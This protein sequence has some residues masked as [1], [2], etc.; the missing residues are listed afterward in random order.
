VRRAALVVLI[1]AGLVG[2]QGVAAQTCAELNAE[3]ARLQQTVA[4][5]QAGLANCRNR[6]GICTPGQEQSFQQAIDIANSEI[7]AD[8]NKLRTACAPPPPPDFD[9]VSLQGIEV[10]QAIQDMSNSVTLVSGKP[11]WVRVYFDKITGT[12]PLTANLV[13]ARGAT[14][15]TIAPA[16]A[17][18]VDPTENL[19]TRRTTWTKSLNFQVPAAMEAVG[20]T[21]FT[22]SGVKD[23]SPQ[24]KTIK[25]AN[26]D[27]PTTVQFLNSP[28]LVV[29]AVG[30]TYTFRS[31]PPPTPLQTGTPRAVDFTLLQSWLGRAYPVSTVTFSQTSAASTNTW[32]FTCTQANAQL[33]ALR[34]TEIAGGRDSHTHY[35]GLVSNAGGFMRGCSSGVPATAD[36]TTT[37]AG[38][39][40]PTSGANTPVNVTGDNDGSF[41][42]WYGGHELA[43]TFGRA[44]PGFCNGNS[45]SDAL[46]PNPNGQLSDGTANAGVGLDVGD[47]ASA[48]ALTVMWGGTNYDVMTYCNQPQWFS[49]YAYEGVRQ[50]LLDENPGFVV[51]ALQKQPATGKTVGQFVHV[52]GSLNLTK[53]TGRIEYVTPVTAALQSVGETGRVVFVARAADGTE[54]TRKDVPL[55]VMTDIPE[56]EDQPGIAEAWIPFSANLG[57]VELVLDGNVVATYQGGKGIPAAVRNVRTT[58]A[59]GN[60]TIQWAPAAGKV[61]Y[62]VQTSADGVDWQTVGVGVTGTQIVLPSSTAIKSV[63]VYANS[64]FRNSAPAMLR[65][66]P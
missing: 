28:A 62:T 40:G 36:P 19:Q 66:K 65:I 59:G 16:A 38:P 45:S 25:C 51:D 47:T 57:K 13:A 37:A 6:P 58:K 46:F 44:H 33:A 30:L 32:P 4:H 63:R 3:I 2:V 60:T 26:C 14:S 22:L 11:T 55:K 9:T 23:A 52:V 34:A 48:A 17:I 21:V 18:T 42:D 50:R 12:R 56:G 61:T 15:A 64:G 10:T 54:I 5:E 7:N 39:A 43:H 1:L 24:N 49:A 31:A 27:T 41:A 29:R 8:V 20:Q 53:N 35:L